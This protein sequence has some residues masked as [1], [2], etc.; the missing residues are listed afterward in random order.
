M[1]AQWYLEP[2][3]TVSVTFDETAVADYCADFNL[4]LPDNGS[5]VAYAAREVK[6][7]GEVELA[8]LNGTM[9]AAGTAVLL[10]GPA[11]TT[12]HMAAVPATKEATTETEAI[13]AEA[14][15]IVAETAGNLF[16]GTYL[17]LTTQRNQYFI[18]DTNDQGQPIMKPNT[19]TNLDANSIYIAITLVPEGLTELTFSN[20]FLGISSPQTATDADTTTPVYDLQGRKIG[21]T[22]RG[23]V[24]QNGRKVI[25]TR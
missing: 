25:G 4:L 5:V 2:V 3:E 20:D 15:D 9:I 7:D 13:A 12:V 10:N 18:L 23:I 22:A 6:A 16:G 24:I 11:N 8:A 19:M 17:K 1:N 21:N 14:K